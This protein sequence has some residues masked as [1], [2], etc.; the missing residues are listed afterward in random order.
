MAKPYRKCFYECCTKETGARRCSKVV[1]HDFTRHIIHHFKRDKQRG[2][3]FV[4]LLKIVLK[5]FPSD[6][7]V[8]YVQFLGETV[9]TFLTDVESGWRCGV[10]YSCIKRKLLYWPVCKYNVYTVFGCCVCLA[11][12]SLTI[13][14]FPLHTITKYKKKRYDCSDRFYCCF[15]NRAVPRC[16]SILRIEN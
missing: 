10:I 16:L 15:R 9:N 11:K 8:H 12:T 7:M 3:R 2:F 1:L 13:V 6:R 4:P 14:F 5:F